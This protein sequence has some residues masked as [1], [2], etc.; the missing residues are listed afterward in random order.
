MDKITEALLLEF[1]NEFGIGL[2]KEDSRFEHFATWL[3]VRRH[4]SE[5]TFDPGNLVTGKGDDTGIDAIGIVVNNNLVTD[6][7]TIDDLLSLNGYLD[8]SFVFVQAE[9]SAHFDTGKIGKFGFGVKDFFGEGKLPRNEAVQSY[10]EIMSAIYAKSAKFRPGNPQ[11]YLYYVTT[12]KWNNEKALTVRAEAEVNDLTATGMFSKVDFV[13]IGADQ[14]QNLYRQTKN[15]ISREFVFDQKVLVPEVGG[16]SEAYLGFLKATE[17]LKLVCDEDGGMIKSLFYENVRDWIGYNP[18]NTEIRGTLSSDFRDRFV[19]MN[20]GVTMIARMLKTTGNKFTMGDFQVVNGC[21]TSHVLHDNSDLL[22]ESVRIP[23]RLICT[24]DEAVIESVIRA[25]NRQTEVQD[26]QFFAMKDFAK[27][28]E[29]YFKTFPVENRIYYERRPHQYDSQDIE[30]SRIIAHQNLVRAV[31]AMFLGEPHITTR[32]FR[33]LASKVGKDMFADTDKLEPYYAAA[34]ALY[35][36][37]RLFKT[38][39]IDARYKAAR[40]Q[41]L[42]A[43]RLLMDAQPLPQMNSNEMAKRCIEMMKP[44]WDDAATEKLFLEAVHKIDD[45]AGT[46]WT[47]DSIRTEPVTKAILAP[48][49]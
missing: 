31:G 43:V 46:G 39:K 7:D 29:T 5:T 17:F 12:G 11:C 25:T 44:L 36:I 8:V 40:Y 18:I 26:V 19:L 49:K 38:G 41:I 6:V 45:V 15:A 28:I 9:R 42:L 21:Q 10:S 32:S 47:R 22:N 33:T 48:G 35:K 20:N 1:S 24:Q 14:I 4:Y 30:K 27:K 2:L 23:F 16:V 3:T 13:P 34:F 37:E